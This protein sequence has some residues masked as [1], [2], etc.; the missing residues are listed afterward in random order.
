MRFLMV[1]Q[2]NAELAGQIHARLELLK[3]RGADFRPEH[4]LSAG[5][6]AKLSPLETLN[7]FAHA[8]IASAAQTLRDLQSNLL[9]KLAQDFENSGRRLGNRELISWNGT[10]MPY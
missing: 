2:S 5:A 9:Q 10:L 1:L 4:V 6:H 3:A 7:A 8:S